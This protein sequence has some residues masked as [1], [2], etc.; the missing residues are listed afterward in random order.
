MSDRIKLEGLEVEAVV[1]VY[2]KERLGP[3]RLIIDVALTT[4]TRPAALADALAATLDY[5]Q[6][7][8]ICRDVAGERLH[9]IE[10]VAERIAARVLAAQPGRIQ[11]VA[12]RVAKPGAV[13][14][15]RTVAV[16]IERKSD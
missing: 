14:G 15:A 9:L 2:P 16:E 13:P 8:E 1:G 6:V 10:T 7:A 3:Q 5:D 11:A 4:D 12:V